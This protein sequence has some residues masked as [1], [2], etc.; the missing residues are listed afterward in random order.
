MSLN[1][2]PEFTLPP[3]APLT[4]IE[5]NADGGTKFKKVNPITYALISFVK[6]ILQERDTVNINEDETGG[7]WTCNY[8]YEEEGD[9]DIFINTFD[10]YEFISLDM[11]SS[12]IDT[13]A[14]DIQLIN[15]FIL[16]QNMGLKVGQL[17][18]LNGTIRFHTSLDV[19]NMASKDP[20]YTGPHLVDPKLIANIFNYAT[21]IFP[22]I[23]RNYSNLNN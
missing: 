11:Y 6:N 23:I 19:R 22:K 2:N 21:Y 4:Q 18:H 12:K 10:E 1:K 13:S 16:E 14:V 7:E 8:S 3:V 20:K 17:Q 9:C 5:K 15:E